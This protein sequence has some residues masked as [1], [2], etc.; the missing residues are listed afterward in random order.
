MGSEGTREK[1]DM[2]KRDGKGVREKEKVQR[3]HEKERVK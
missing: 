1:K 2:S 3:R